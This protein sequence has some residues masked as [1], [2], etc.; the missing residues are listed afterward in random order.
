M[1][2]GTLSQRELAIKLF[3]DF[4][5][6]VSVIRHKCYID[7]C[8]EAKNYQPE[9]LKILLTNEIPPE[10]AY[11]WARYIGDREL[12][13]PLIIGSEWAFNWARY[14]GDREL[15]RPLITESKWA[16]YWAR[17]I[18]DRE[19]MRPLIIGSEWAHFWARYKGNDK[20]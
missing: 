2:A 10:W 12:M 17:Y 3:T 16:Y 20:C 18:G 11:N 14:I 7:I 9:V 19:L 6:L 4:P 8:E 1:L 13:R 15:M 5:T